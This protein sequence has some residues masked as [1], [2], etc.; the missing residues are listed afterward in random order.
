MTMVMVWVRKPLPA[1]SNSKR[2]SKKTVKSTV[3]RTPIYYY[4]TIS[5]HLNEVILPLTREYPQTLKTAIFF[6]F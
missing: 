5:Y 6:C 2:N 3:K 1:A 4:F